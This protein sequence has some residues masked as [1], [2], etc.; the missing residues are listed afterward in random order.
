[1]LTQI[2]PTTVF[3]LNSN[4]YNQKHKPR[5]GNAEPWKQRAVGT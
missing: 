3:R 1:M 5:A 4:N 2:N